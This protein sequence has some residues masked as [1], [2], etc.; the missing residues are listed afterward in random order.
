[1]AT[2]SATRTLVLGY[3]LET[4]SKE[5]DTRLR[6]ESS[7]I[8]RAIACRHKESSDSLPRFLC[9]DIGASV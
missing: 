4:D 1:M 7:K 9:D 6:G 5:A 2:A 8:L 3:E